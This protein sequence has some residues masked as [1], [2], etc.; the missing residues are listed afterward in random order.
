MLDTKAKQ[1]SP[2]A[3]NNA[4]ISGTDPYSDEALISPWDTYRELRDLGPAV[5]LMQCRPLD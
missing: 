4:A 5:G 2:P 1:G 3:P